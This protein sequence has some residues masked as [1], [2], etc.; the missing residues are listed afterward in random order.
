MAITQLKLNNVVHR[1]EAAS[2]GD[3]RLVIQPTVIKAISQA[4]QVNE[5]G[6]REIDGLIDEHLLPDVASVL[7]NKQGR[8]GVLTLSFSRQRYQCQWKSSGS[9]GH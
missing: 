6:V 3:V 8:R 4:C 9:N 7:L 2:V 5:I 1:L